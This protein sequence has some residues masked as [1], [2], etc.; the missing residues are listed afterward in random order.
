M[1]LSVSLIFEH[2]CVIYMLKLAIE[3]V[4]SHKTLFNEFGSLHLHLAG[5]MKII[6]QFEFLAAD[7]CNWVTLVA[8][9]HVDLARS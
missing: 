9:L 8:Q 5:F 1:N 4:L 3:R 6:K 7:T 2:L